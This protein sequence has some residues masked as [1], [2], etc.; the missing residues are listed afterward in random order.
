MGSDP[1]KPTTM[2]NLSTVEVP[3]FFIGK[4]LVT[5]SLWEV[6]MSETRPEFKGEKTARWRL[7]RGLN[8][9]VFSNA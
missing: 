8:V 5:Q 7:F 9:M 3:S 2:K 1:R 4:L 6:V